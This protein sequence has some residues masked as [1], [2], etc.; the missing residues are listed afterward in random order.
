MFSL[1][2]MSRKVVNTFVFIS[3]NG[4]VSVYAVRNALAYILILFCMW[5]L[6]LSRYV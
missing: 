2:I 4:K 1:P 3:M 6:D 5:Q